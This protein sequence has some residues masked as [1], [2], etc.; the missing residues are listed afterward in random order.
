[1][2]SERKRAG[3]KKYAERLARELQVVA[4]RFGKAQ[5]AAKDYILATQP[6][7]LTNGLEETKI[8]EFLTESEDK[9][10]LL[11]DRMESVIRQEPWNKEVADESGGKLTD[12]TPLGV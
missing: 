2:S 7:G 11:N 1:M 8:E 9:L 3:V 6:N 10:R 4:D 5:A 12:E